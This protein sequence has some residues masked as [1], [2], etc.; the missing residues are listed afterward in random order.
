MTL[1]VA[2]DPGV[3][4]AIAFVRGSDASVIDMPVFKL[5]GRAKY[6]VRDIARNLREQDRRIGIQVLIEEAQVFTPGKLAI[7]GMARC[8]GIFEGIC[9]AMGLPYELVSPTVWKRQVG[10]A[11]KD[12]DASRRLASQK[13][14]SVDLSRKKDDGRAEALLLTWWWQYGRRESGKTYSEAQ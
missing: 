1:I 11:G 7:A 8:V 2:V 5:G 10:L 14:P 6:D 13:F 4:G 12:K 9:A 3:N